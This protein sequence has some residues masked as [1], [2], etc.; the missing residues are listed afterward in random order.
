MLDLF[1]GAGG[2]AMGYYRAGFDVV[3]VDLHPQPHYPF[4][5]VQADA[6]EYLSET[7]AVGFDAIHASPPCQA[8]STLRHRTG[9]SYPDLVAETRRLLVASGLTY[10]IENVPGSPLDSPVWLCGTEFDLSAAATTG[11]TRWLRRHRGFESNL[12]LRGAGGCVH[13]GKLVGG[14]YGDGGGGQQTRGWRYETAAQM[15]DAMDTPWMTRQEMSQ[16]IPPAY[17][18]H[19][20][21]QLLASIEAV[22]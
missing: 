10:V 2:A 9:G 4:P 1:S 15:R 16:A 13:A 11:E 5:F 20:G 18:E 17:T 12:W 8:Y 22:A 3:G 6:I 14:I 21:R 19:I 7:M